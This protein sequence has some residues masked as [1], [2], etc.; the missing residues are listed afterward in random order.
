M[1]YPHIDCVLVSFD[2]VEAKTKEADS[3]PHWM[4][5]DLVQSWDT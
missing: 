5:E 2:L 1:V 4:V 3:M